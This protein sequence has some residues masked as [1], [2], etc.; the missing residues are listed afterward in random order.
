MLR[1]KYIKNKNDSG[2]NT[3]SKSVSTN[4]N[5][6]VV[7]TNK[8]VVNTN[9]PVVNTNKP[10]VNTNK[11]VVNTNKPV[12]N[13]NK[14]VVNT[15]KPVVNTNKPVVNTNKPVV[16]T[17]KPVVNTNKPV[18]N[19]NKPVVNTNKP[20]V[21][22]NKDISI[23]NNIKNE[24]NKS[25]LDI[26]KNINDGINN[27]IQDS[28]NK[29][30]D[31]YNKTRNKLVNKVDSVVNNA[32]GN[33]ST[34]GVVQPSVQ[35]VTQP[36]VQ[37]ATQPS[38]QQATQSSNQK[39]KTVTDERGFPQ[40]EQC[41]SYVDQVVEDVIEG[42]DKV[43]NALL[44]RNITENMDSKTLEKLAELENND[45]PPLKIIDASRDAT[46]NITN[47]AIHFAVTTGAVGLNKVL[48][49]VSFTILGLENLNIENKEEILQQLEE[50]VILLQ[51]LANDEK[52]KVLVKKLFGSLA[53]MIMEGSEVAKEPLLRAF[54][55]I[56]KTTVK[57]VNSIMKS[58]TKFIKNAI[59][60]IPVVGDAYIILDNILTLGAAGSRAGVMFAKNAETLSYTADDVIKRVQ[61]KIQP[62]VEDYEN[63]MEEI[64]RIRNNLENI[65][66]QSV[67]RG[68]E[69]K[70]AYKIKNTGDNTSKAIYNITP[71]L[72]TKKGGKKI[73]SSLKK[74]KNKKSKKVRFKI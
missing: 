44:N 10:V 19:T 2:L 32:T 29:F 66:I 18:V 47:A 67:I 62:P 42:G 7:N 31:M 27:S 57:G 68:A 20:V 74:N 25:V 65:D 69:S 41:T 73:K 50:K 63:S 11:P 48:D 61:S 40:P 6:P 70:L 16:N 36:S 72:N 64:N 35:Q 4:T 21:N 51:Y 14:P 23:V 39:P 1:S 60:I 22:T 52:S 43:D 38:V 53:L 58:G 28:K 3:S 49:I 56:S 71:K 37:Q 26:K 55:N 17:N 45:L 24:A 15:N 5:K 13:T 54:L 12:V 34:T 8:P 30:A 46:T 33:T 59:K 9:K